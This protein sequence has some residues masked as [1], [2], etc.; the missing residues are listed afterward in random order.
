MYRP[1]RDSDNSSILSTASLAPSYHST[2][3]A[4]HEQLIAPEYRAYAQSG[5]RLN[6]SQSTSSD[7]APSL[8]VYS[9]PGFQSFNIPRNEAALAKIAKRRHSDAMTQT[10]RQFSINHDREEQVRGSSAS[11]PMLTRR[12][13]STRIEL[14]VLHEEHRC[15]LERDNEVWDY[16][17]M[18]LGAYP[19]LEYYQHRAR[20]L[21]NYEARELRIKEAMEKYCGGRG[22]STLC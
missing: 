12:R 16:G 9:I 4:S 6:R 22:G 15:P 13:S 19:S 10:L 2:L 17:F 1:R 8:N 3:P 18:C 21:T 7:T 5:P 20:E 11:H 14:P